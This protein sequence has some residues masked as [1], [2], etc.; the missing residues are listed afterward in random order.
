M[1]R[2]YT[3]VSTAKWLLENNVTSVGTTM[4]N[5]YGIPKEVKLLVGR[6]DLSTRV[7]WEAENH[8]LVQSSYCVKTAQGMK[9]VL[10]L[11]TIYPLLG[12][13]KEKT[14]FIQTI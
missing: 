7:F 10:L 1:N 6:E 8:D 2:L 11:S 5:H 12:V 9:N 14:S 4:T 3:S 13:T